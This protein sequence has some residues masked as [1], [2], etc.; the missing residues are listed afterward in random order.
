MSFG[1]LLNGPFTC[2][3][4][5]LS[6]VS[7]RTGYVLP[8]IAI[9]LQASILFSCLLFSPFVSIVRPFTL[10]SVLLLFSF[11]NRDKPAQVPS[12][13]ESNQDEGET[14]SG[15]DG[16]GGTE[17]DGEEGKR[18]GPFYPS[19]KEPPNHRQ[20]EEEQE[21]NNHVEDRDKNIDNGIEVENS[22]E[23]HSSRPKVSEESPSPDQCEEEEENNEETED[24]DEEAAEEAAKEAVVEETVVQEA[25]VNAVDMQAGD[26]DDEE[27]PVQEA[28]EEAEEEADE[29]RQPKEAKRSDCGEMQDEEAEDSSHDQS[30]EKK[31]NNE[32]NEDTERRKQETEDAKRKQAQKEEARNE[33]TQQQAWDRDPN[34]SMLREL[35]ALGRNGLNARCPSLSGICPVPPF[36][37]TQAPTLSSFNA[38]I[39][40]GPNPAEHFRVEDLMP[41]LL[42]MVQCIA[43]QLL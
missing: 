41:G 27:G 40:S 34:V 6:G 32:K 14:A 25:V 39:T 9:V 29:D 4:L 19:R 20:N 2:S 15:D 36:P 5:L 24:D 8:S 17:S 11:P 38:V 35:A 21:K 3:S 18:E 7:S 42:N 33:E 43:L 28:V 22:A 12:D 30:E 13:A 31:E 1:S 10:S 26:P 16:E 23:P 37:P